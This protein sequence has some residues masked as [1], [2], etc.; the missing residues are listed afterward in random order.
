M[1]YKPACSSITLSSLSLSAA[2]SAAWKLAVSP[3]A[4]HVTVAACAREPANRR[5]IATQALLKTRDVLG[6]TC[7]RFMGRLRL[8]GL[9][10]DYEKAR[11]SGHAV[12]PGRID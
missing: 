5:R 2:A 1:T 4:M 10:R 9:N 8:V 7:G 12:P 3:A 11:P 6:Q